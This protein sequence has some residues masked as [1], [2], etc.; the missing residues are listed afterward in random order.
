MAETQVEKFV[1]DAEG[2]RLF[3]Q[4]RVILE[5]TMRVCEAMEE[6][7]MSRKEL[8]DVL[9][10]SK[11]HVSQ[12]LDGRQ[13]MTLRTLSDV[14]GALGL[15]VHIQTAPLERSVKPPVT[16]SMEL[17]TWDGRNSWGRSC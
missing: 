17:G 4:E 6:K 5:A 13:N 8:A 1:R 10:K 3:Q 11:S 16:F 12:L 15:A 9:G 7:G 14:F 2:M